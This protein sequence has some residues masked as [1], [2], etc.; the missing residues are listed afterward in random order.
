MKPGKLRLWFELM[1]AI[2]GIACVLAI[3]FATVGAAASGASEDSPAGGSDSTAGRLVQSVQAGQMPPAVTQQS[4]TPLQTYEGVVADTRCGAKHSPT[5]DQNAADCTRQCVHAGEHFALVDGEKL[6]VLEG[7][8]ELLKQAAG[9]R[10]TIIGI[11]L[12]SN[13][14]SVASVR[15]P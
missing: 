14:I 6:Y 9:V 12:N 3:F 4:S 1:A 10:V 15:L 13:T 5:I 11:P 2:T 7:Q 8:P